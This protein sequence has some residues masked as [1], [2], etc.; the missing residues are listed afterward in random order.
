MREEPTVGA[1][2]EGV[3][4]IPVF[5]CLPELIIR[6]PAGVVFF[7]TTP[8]VCLAF[9]CFAAITGSADR[10]AAAGVFKIAG[11]LVLAALC[12]TLVVLS[13]REPTFVV[14]VTVRTSRGSMRES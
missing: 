6:P 5:C 3:A 14:F 9:A 12:P 2:V 13:T 1:T 4:T 10:S 8:V 7:A 11:T